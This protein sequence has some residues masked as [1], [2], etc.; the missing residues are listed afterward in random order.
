MFS[1]RRTVFVRLCG[2]NPC[3]LFGNQPRCISQQWF[4]WWNRRLVLLISDATLSK[5]QH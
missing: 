3:S 2:A 4:S 5:Q 1:C